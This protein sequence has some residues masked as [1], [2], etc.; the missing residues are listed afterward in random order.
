MADAEIRDKLVASGL[1]PAWEPAAAVAARIEDEL[2][3]MRAIARQANIR[4]D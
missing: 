3:R 4:A 2:P 1:Q